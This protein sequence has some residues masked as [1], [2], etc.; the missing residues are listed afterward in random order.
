MQ[1]FNYSSAVT[2]FFDFFLPRFCPSCNKKLSADEVV[3]CPYCLS[4]IKLAEDERI[5][6]EFNRKFSSDGIISEFIS[7]YVFEKDKE[8]QHII[9]SLKYNNKFLTGK[10]LG[11]LISNQLK[12]K[13]NGWKIDYITPVPL[14]HLKKADRGYNQSFYIAKGLSKGLTI[15][16]S[17]GFIKRKKYTKSQTTMSLKERQENIEGAFK[18]KRNLNLKDKNILLIDDVITTGS[19]IGECGKILLSAGANKVYAASVAIAD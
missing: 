12:E 1:S 15:P 6:S 14:H 17:E 2:S 10:F 13:I 9:H 5:K 7:L 11:S 4:K 16:I 8:L 18:A 19:T 3:V